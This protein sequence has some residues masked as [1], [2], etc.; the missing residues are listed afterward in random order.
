MKEKKEAFTYTYSAAQQ[1]EVRR[2]REKY[3]PVAS[4]EGRMAQL[5]RLDQAVTKP[6]MVAALSLGTVSTLILGLG[7]CCTM[8]WDEALFIPGIVI[9]LLGILGICAAYPLYLHITKKRRDKLAP[10]IVRLA[11]DLMK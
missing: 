8:V 6:G 1:E 2:I 11:D 10:E 4:E 3:A 5:R 9:G 7:M